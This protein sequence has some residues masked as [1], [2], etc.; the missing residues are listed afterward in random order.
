MRDEVSPPGEERHRQGRA[1]ADGADEVLALIRIRWALV[2]KAGVHAQVWHSLRLR[3]G[4][5]RIARAFRIFRLPDLR[6]VVFGRLERLRD[7]SGQEIGECRLRGQIAG[8]LADD[9][10][11]GRAAGRQLGLRQG[12]LRFGGCEAR[13]RLRHVS[14]GDLADFEAG[15]GFVELP[16]KDAEILLPN[17]QRLL[18]APNV[19]IGLDHRLH[20]RRFGTAK[21]FLPGQNVRFRR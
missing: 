5:P 17:T 13:L 8:V 2:T 11:I 9:C 21:L 10:G 7:I 4:Q 15:L 14:P 19:G 20:Y 3:G 1:R 12:K 18:V 6:I 16:L